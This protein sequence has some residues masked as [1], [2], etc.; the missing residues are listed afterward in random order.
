LEFNV[1]LA[2]VS[3]VPL[4]AVVYHLYILAAEY[5]GTVYT[6]TA[7]SIVQAGA[8]YVAVFPSCG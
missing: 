5:P 3:G 7:A 6:S 1:T 2:L 4:T 8:I